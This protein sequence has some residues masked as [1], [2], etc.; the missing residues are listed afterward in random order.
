[1]GYVDEKYWSLKSPKTVWKIDNISLN[2]YYITTVCNTVFFSHLH[3]IANI[4]FKIHI[5]VERQ[6]LLHLCEH[7]AY[8]TKFIQEAAD[9]RLVLP[10]VTISYFAPVQ[11]LEFYSYRDVVLHRKTSDISRP[12]QVLG[13]MVGVFVSTSVDITYWTDIAAV[14]VNVFKS[15]VY[16]L[17]CH[18]TKH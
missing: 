15:P 14:V 18:S 6:T 8:Y 17:W 10:I 4:N 11:T 5:L 16:R 3:S 12:V 9:F 2:F 7:W 1:M 13:K